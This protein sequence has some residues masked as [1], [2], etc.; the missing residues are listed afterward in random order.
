MLL[1]SHEKNLTT[2]NTPEE[3]GSAQRLMDEKIRNIWRESRGGAYIA[4]LFV[5]YFLP[6]LIMSRVGL[7]MNMD[8]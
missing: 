4:P 2:I 6:L 8:E 7:A 3:I 5:S 1:H